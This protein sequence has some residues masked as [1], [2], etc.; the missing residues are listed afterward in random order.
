MLAGGIVKV[1][2]YGKVLRFVLGVLALSVLAD[3]LPARADTD[4]GL[5]YF[6][7]GQFSEA[8][9]AWQAAAD[10]GDPAAA[11]YLGVLFDTG[12]GVGQDYR[13]ALDWYQRGGAAG[14]RTA[15]F[16]AAVMFDAGRGTPADL[17]TAVTWYERA[18]AAGFGRAEDHLG[19]IYED[20]AGVARDRSR[21]GRLFQDAARHGVAAARSHLVALGLPYAGGAPHPTI[22]VA[23][24][25][26]EQ[27]EH[28]LLSRGTGEAGK[29]A[30]LF[31]Q[32]A[33]AGNPLA[34][35]NLAYCY[36]HGLGVAPDVDQAI[37]WYRRSAAEAGTSP[38]RELAENGA[39][40]LV[41]GVYHVQR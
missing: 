41:S 13:R 7:S 35:Y 1:T 5:R 15:M 23:M 33:D 29:A 18:A 11:L 28:L 26:F 16:N 14:N 19:L 17:P 36:E 22:D 25:R 24:V 20:G 12:T 2:P 4:A 8:V 9:Q 37:T 27:A 30:E 3:V 21:A 38:V 40:N 34:A 32:A 10:Q 6:G 31:R 39:R